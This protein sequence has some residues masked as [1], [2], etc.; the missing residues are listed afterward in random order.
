MAN[1]RQPTRVEGSHETPRGFRS[2]EEEDT[3][4]LDCHA[5]KSRRNVCLALGIGLLGFHVSNKPG[6]IVDCL[7]LWGCPRFL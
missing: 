4:V 1:S 7:L 6:S 3:W 2:G 5:E